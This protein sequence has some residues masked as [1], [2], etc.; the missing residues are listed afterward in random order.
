MI[1]FSKFQILKA[2]SLK[3]WGNS[4]YYIR[5]HFSPDTSIRAYNFWDYQNAWDIVLCFQNI[6]FYVSK[7]FATLTWFI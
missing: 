3:E 6:Q 4:L 2:I 7:T 5:L 1:A